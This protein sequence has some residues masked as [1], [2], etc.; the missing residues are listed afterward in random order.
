MVSCVHYFFEH[1]GLREK[2]VHLHADNCSRQ[3]INDCMLHYLVWR[4]LTE[5]YT[6]I[7]LSYLPVRHTKFSPDWCFGLFKRQ[8]K[9]TKI[10]RVQ[11]V[12]NKSAECNVAQLVSQEDGS[13]IVTTFNWTDVIAMQMTKFTRIKKFYHF[14]A[15]SSLGCVFVWEQSDLY[16]V[17]IYLLKEPWTPDVNELPAVVPPHGLKAEQQWYLYEQIRPFCPPE[18]MDSVCPLP[19]IPK[20]G[21]IKS[22]WLPIPTLSRRFSPT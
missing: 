1:H 4:T 21:G 16:E 5:W 6:T 22:T 3:N 20:L 7:E 8:Y 17:K 19:S 11:E 12:V 2:H 13:I 15:T 10:G 18:D 9:W 14:W